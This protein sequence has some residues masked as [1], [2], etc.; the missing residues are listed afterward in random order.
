[1]GWIY[2]IDLR[3]W[4]VDAI[5]VMTAEEGLVDGYNVINLLMYK[6]DEPVEQN[7]KVN[8][9]ISGVIHSVKFIREKKMKNLLG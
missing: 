4:V 3:E 5:V 8:K 2:G 1:M 6:I 9:H 7:C